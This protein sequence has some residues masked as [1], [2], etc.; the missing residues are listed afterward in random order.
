MKLDD[1]DRKIL[2]RLQDDASSPIETIA[3][4][5]GLSRNA[6]WRRIKALEANNV[7]T[8]RIALVDPQTVG[9]G[10][11]AFIMIRANRHEPE[12]IE[13]FNRAVQDI[14]EIVG[15]YRTSG[16][17]D[18][19][20]RVRVADMAGYDLLYQKLI[21]KVSLSDVSATFVME[22]IKETFAVPV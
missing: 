16:D 18:Y 6:C 8:R 14:P 17:I 15:V 13:T 10:L 11:S 9:A 3:S 20:V 12:W 21:R 22:T 19:I 4:E 5:V 1:F 2:N 7:L